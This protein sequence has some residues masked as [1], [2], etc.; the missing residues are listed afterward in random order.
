MKVGEVI[1]GIQIANFDT[2]FYYKW[3]KDLKKDFKRETGIETTAP[4]MLKK[5]LQR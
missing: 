4:S 1:G 5:L 3:H 2:E